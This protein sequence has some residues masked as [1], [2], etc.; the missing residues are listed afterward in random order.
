MVTNDRITNALGTKRCANRL[1]HKRPIT[2]EMVRSKLR[3]KKQVYSKHITQAFRKQSKLH[4][5]KNTCCNNINFG[6]PDI[7]YG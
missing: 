6:R 1:A 5:K 2:P 4:L 3:K 7:N